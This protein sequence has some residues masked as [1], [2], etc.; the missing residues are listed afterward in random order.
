MSRLRLQSRIVLQVL[1]AMLLSAA[2]AAAAI[3]GL[4][5]TGHSVAGSL[6]RSGEVQHVRRANDRRAASCA[7]PPCGA[8]V[9]PDNGTTTDANWEIAV[10]YP[11]EPSSTPVTDP[12]VLQKWVPA[13]VDTPDTPPWLADSNVYSEWITPQVENSRANVCC[14]CRIATSS[15]LISWSSNC[16][17]LGD[18]VILKRRVRLELSR[19]IIAVGSRFPIALSAEGSQEAHR[20]TGGPRSLRTLQR[21]A[22]GF[23]PRPDGELKFAAAR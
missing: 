11:T 18:T 8:L 16:T 7:R 9:T 19:F 1:S 21:A 6:P 12:C 2:V 23:S 5:N 4:C 10:P 20:Q 17:K 13:W 3:P 14:T 22:A 15:I